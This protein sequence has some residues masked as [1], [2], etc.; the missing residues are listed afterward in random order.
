MPYRSCHG[1]KR[2]RELPPPAYQF[3]DEFLIADANPLV[4]PRLCEPG[5]GTLDV[6]DLDGRLAVSGGALTFSGASASWDR[7]YL[8]CP[9]AFVRKKGRFLE[10]QLTP[11]NT[12][13]HIVAWQ[14]S[15]SGVIGQHEAGVRFGGAGFVLAQ[16]GLDP[17]ATGYPYSS[18]TSYGIRIY[19]GGDHYAMYIRET[20]SS[21]WTILWRRTLSSAPLVTQFVGLNN[22]AL[23][24]SMSYIR[25]RPGRLPQP[26]HFV[27]NPVPNELSCGHAD[28]LT[29]VEIEAPAAGNP[30]LYFRYASATNHWKLV[31]NRAGNTMDLV[32]VVAGTP[33]VVG[34]TAV[35]WV[36]GER[37]PFRVLHFGNYI[38]SFLGRLAGTL[39]TDAFNNTAEVIGVST[40]AEFYNIRQ[41]VGGDLQW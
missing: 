11:T 37:Y 28:G 27:A 41:D 36:T 17:V 39:T 20:T 32:K 15:A 40:G 25:V 33:S 16:D 4:N 35:T 24:G 22:I 30:A 3:D 31:L 29:E 34:T 13:D 6:T 26:H 1:K 14:K 5:P 18:G 2:R 19:D 12:G 9:I 21:T 23:T 10:W 7:T 38:R 8:S